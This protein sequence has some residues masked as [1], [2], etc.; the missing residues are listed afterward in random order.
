[1][2][3]AVAARKGKEIAVMVVS[4]RPRI[5]ERA[6]AWGPKGVVVV[7]ALSSKELAEKAYAMLEE[8]EKALEA[9]LNDPLA[10]YRQALLL[11]RRGEVQA[12]TGMGTV[13]AKGFVKGRIGRTEL[14]C[15]GNGLT[16]SRV[17]LE[18]CKAGDEEPLR[19]VFDMALA[20]EEVGG[21]A[22][23][24]RS[25]VLVYLGSFELFER[26]DESLNPVKEMLERV[27]SPPLLAFG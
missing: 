25:A 11:P 3:Y 18:A 14:Y 9:I 22:T 23:G 21:N 24:S 26:V 7:Q 2:T 16:S 17:L 10:G 13:P 15:I 6:V 5:A 19:A 1:M 8:P 27:T 4:P 12:F 20:A